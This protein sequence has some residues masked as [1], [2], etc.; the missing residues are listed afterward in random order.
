MMFGAEL[1]ATSEALLDLCRRKRILIATAESCTGGLIAG[2]LTSIAGSSDVVDGGFVTYSNGAKTA[3][4]GVPSDLIARHGA[5]SSEV[6][7]AMAEGALRHS[8]ATLA[9]SVTGIAGPGGATPGKP[10]GLVYIAAAAAGKCQVR[11]LKLGDAGREN[12]R[13]ASV[14]A[15]LGLAYAMAEGLP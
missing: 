3:M 5:V 1:T 11:E 6:A 2:V 14:S 15:A 10:V 12:V 7:K 13:L 9:I 8:R 4:I